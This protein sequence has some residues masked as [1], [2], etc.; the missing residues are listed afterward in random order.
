[1]NIVIKSHLPKLSPNVTSFCT[2]LFRLFCKLL[3]LLKFLRTLELL[4]ALFSGFFF[5]YFLGAFALRGCISWKV[6]ETGEATLE[7]LLVQL[8]EFRSAWRKREK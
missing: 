4:T 3:S 1:M 7:F 5:S 6:G 8:H 2:R